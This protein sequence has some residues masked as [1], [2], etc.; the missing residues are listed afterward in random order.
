VA[1]TPAERKALL[2]LAI[3]GVLGMGARGLSST[4]RWERERPTGPDVAA[5]DAQLAAVDSALASERRPAARSRG[6]P[7]RRS[8]AA[9][10]RS[11]SGTDAAPSARERRT[12]S[13]RGAGARAAPNAGPVDVDVADAA[14]LEALPGI[15]PAL[16]ERIVADR[17]TGGAYGSL[18][19]LAQV[20]GVGP[21][22]LAR[23]SSHVTFSGTPRPT[24][25]GDRR[26][27]PR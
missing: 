14:A 13:R 18:E 6:S 20:R 2:F 15:G 11:A 25:A 16:A 1:V 7:P 9:R 10:A 19:A 12:A 4:D 24:Q 3:I 26:R 27:A 22:L 21:K 23:L 5:L 8:R 17:V